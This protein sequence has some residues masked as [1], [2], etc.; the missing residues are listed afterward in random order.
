[1][2]LITIDKD[3]LE[4]I[5][6]RFDNLAERREEHNDKLNNLL[7][8]LQNVKSGGFVEEIVEK[9]EDHIEDVNKNQLGNVVYTSDFLR[10][11]IDEFTTLDEST[12]L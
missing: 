6:K 8:N 7:D 1:M 10:M 4:E 3:E 12:K 2:S 11:L 9:L 5:K